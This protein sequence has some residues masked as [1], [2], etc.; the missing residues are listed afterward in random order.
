MGEHILLAMFA[1]RAGSAASPMGATAGKKRFSVGDL[2]A[3][4]RKSRGGHSGGGGRGS[5]AGILAGQILDAAKRLM[6]RRRLELYLRE[7]NLSISDTTADRT[8]MAYRWD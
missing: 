5:E 4:S 8:N 2:Y 3:L 1:G 7:V 6:E